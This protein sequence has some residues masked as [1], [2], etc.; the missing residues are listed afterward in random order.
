MAM[1][2]IPI[3]SKRLE[4]VS[5]M[6]EKGPVGDI[7]TD[8]GLLAIELA[9]RGLFVI[10]TDLNKKPLEAAKANI[11]RYGQSE[12]VELRLGNGLAPISPGDVNTIVICGM[13]GQLIIDIINNHLDVAKSAERL[14]LSPQSHQPDVRRFLHRAGFRINDE[15]MVYEDGIYY[16][17]MDCEP[18]YQEIFTESEYAFGKTLSD[19]RPDLF[20]SYITKEQQ[21]VESAIRKI[22]RNGSGDPRTEERLLALRMRLDMMNKLKEG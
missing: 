17:I 18:G 13:G 12:K 22:N 4:T 6:I 10:A 21:L 9:S 7:G 3:L 16:F 14:I 19:R 15:Q 2:E 8:H 1:R 11:S 5:Q 20:L